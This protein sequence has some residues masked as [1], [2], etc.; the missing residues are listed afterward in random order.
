MQPD[1]HGGAVVGAAGVAE[2]LRERLALAQ[3]AVD[4]DELH[5][6]DD[7]VAPIQLLGIRRGHAFKHGFDVY[8]LCRRAGRRTGCRGRL[9]SRRRRIRR[10][11][12]VHLRLGGTRFVTHDL[13][14]QI[15]E[16]AHDLTL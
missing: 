14:H 5:Q 7:G 2:F 1:V 16:Y 10:D 8:R 3:P 12:R 9:C 6:V 11:G 13:R 15:A 4:A